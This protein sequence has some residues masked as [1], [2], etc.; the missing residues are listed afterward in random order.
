MDALILAPRGTAR[1]VVLLSE[2]QVPD[3]WHIAMM[4]KEKG[5][6]D[7]HIKVL[8]TW[9]LCH[10]LLAYAKGDEDYHERALQG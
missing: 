2:V 10:D 3:L 9:H 5:Y 6:L 4:L 7:E 8:E 1:K